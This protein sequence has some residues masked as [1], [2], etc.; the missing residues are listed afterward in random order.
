MAGCVDVRG[1]E[2]W[3]VVVGGVVFGTVV[4][5]LPPPPLLR[6]FLTARS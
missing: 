4:V 3:V 5:P 2:V 1:V 6:A